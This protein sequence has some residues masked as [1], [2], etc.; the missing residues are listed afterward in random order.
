MQEN[1]QTWLTDIGLGHLGELFIEQEVDFDVLETLTESD[2]KEMGIT[3]LGARKRLLKAIGERN[4]APAAQPA[5]VQPTPVPQEPRSPIRTTV[6]PAPQPA[7][8]APQA[9]PTQE[10]E[11][12]A[13]RRHLTVMF[14]DM[15]DSTVLASTHDPED[16]QELIQSYHQA[17]TQAVLPFEGY[18]AK[19]PGDGALV[20]FGYPHAYE[21]TATRCVRA[22]MAV[23]KAV[24]Q[25]RQKNGNPLSTR[26]GV[27]T[28][29]VVFS[30]VGAGTAAAEKSAAGDTLNLAARL[31]NVAK[32]GQIVVAGRTRYLLE[33]SFDVESLGKTDIKGFGFPIEVWLLRGERQVSSRF[34]ARQSNA[35]IR[36]VGR[37][38]EVSLLLE[39][40]QMARDGDGQI[41]LLSGEAGIGKSRIT[42]TLKERIAQ[43]GPVIVQCQCSPYFGNSALYP[44]VKYLEHAS[45]L[46]ATDDADTKKVKLNALLAPGLSVEATQSLL[47]LM[48]LPHDD[49][50]FQGLSPQQEKAQVLR[51][52][53]D[54]VIAFSKIKPVLL[55]LEDAHWIDPTTEELLAQL[56]HR[57]RDTSILAVVTCRPEYKPSW[58]NAAIDTAQ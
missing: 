55:F 27:A 4:G 28:G 36:F 40:W 56:T 34:E 24:D 2:L 16:F 19:F 26:I 21:D 39:R 18:V 58:A 20:Y 10:R 33:S 32:P 50:L 54:L 37:E 1:I 14:C 8:A 52:F 17:V 15:V 3:A 13:E 45:A 38:S 6:A 35:L 5:V 46:L 25:L 51:A 47:R 9:A 12:S 7:T 31:Q 53:A 44:V 22:A 23:I 30:D 11:S 29:T 48:A 42:Y 49:T 41:V 43:D 57:V